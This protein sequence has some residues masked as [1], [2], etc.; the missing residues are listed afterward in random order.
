MP[1][2]RPHLSGREGGYGGESVLIFRQS[3]FFGKCGAPWTKKNRRKKRRISC[4]IFRQSRCFGKMWPI[5]HQIFSAKKKKKKLE[6]RP[7]DGHVEH[8]VQN[9]SGWR[10]HLFG[11]LCVKMSKMRYFRKLLGFSVGSSFFA[12]FC[13]M[14]ITGGSDLRFFARKILQVACL[15]VPPTNRF[16]Q[17]AAR[18][19]SSPPFGKSLNIIERYEKACV[20]VLLV[21][22]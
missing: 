17:N 13:L 7:R 1:L 8:V 15:G 2:R 9:F 11:L 5:I 6:V 18:S 14:F 22:Y 3:R 4:L 10:G 20:K 19:F 16:V 12:R 21:G